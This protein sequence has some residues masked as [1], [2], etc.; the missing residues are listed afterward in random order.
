MNWQANGCKFTVWLQQSQSA[1]VQLR[2]F[3][4]M[5]V[6]SVV[7]EVEDMALGLTAS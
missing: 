7:K 6:E 3:V 2:V 1:V 5:N 4:L